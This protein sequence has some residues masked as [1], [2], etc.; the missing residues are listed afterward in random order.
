VALDAGYRQSLDDATSRQL[1]V[2]LRV[3]MF[4]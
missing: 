2:S 4:E 3:F 1:G